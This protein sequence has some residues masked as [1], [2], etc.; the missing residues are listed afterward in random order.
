MRES[1]PELAMVADEHENDV[2]D[3][4]KQQTRIAQTSAMNRSA[5]VASSAAASAAQVNFG[6]SG[7]TN[8]GF[9]YSGAPTSS[10][11]SHARNNATQFGFSGVNVDEYA[12]SAHHSTSEAR[13][14]FSFR[15]LESAEDKSNSRALH[16]GV[17]TGLSAYESS[18]GSS[19]DLSATA[20][21]Q[22]RQLTTQLSSSFDFEAE[23]EAE[24]IEDMRQ[25]QIGYPRGQP[26]SVSF[27]QSQ[28][29]PDAELHAETQSVRL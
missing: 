8:R 1:A 25:G 18:Q 3:L 19:T 14:H 15:R 2:D 21:E 27:L 28:R 4:H 10:A 23:F 24:H 11:A 20:A 7:A 22:R 13:D 29:Y 26:R 12:E 9:G 5:G 17:S 6:I 16:Y